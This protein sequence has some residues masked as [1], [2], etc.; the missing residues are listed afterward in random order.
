VTGEKLL[1]GG[2]EFQGGKK[3]GARLVFVLVRRYRKGPLQRSLGRRNVRGN[4][5]SLGKGEREANIPI[6]QV[7]GGKE[8]KTGDPKAE[9][10]GEDYRV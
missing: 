7:Q 10:K 9:G 1:G 3:K 8:E 5:P 2:K 4:L 6:C